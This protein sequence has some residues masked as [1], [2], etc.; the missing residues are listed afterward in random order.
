MARTPLLVAL[1]F[2]LAL[3]STASASGLNLAW[4]DC[5]SF[6]TPARTFACDTNAGTHVLVASLVAPPGI[7]SCVA[8]EIVIDLEVAAPTLNPWLDFTPNACRMNRA[9]TAFTFGDLASCLDP[10]SGQGLGASDF[11]T[12]YPQLNRER[13][14]TVGAVPEAAAIP[15]SPGGEYYMVEL[16]I[17]NAKTVGTG[18]CAG[19]QVQGIFEFVSV[20]ITQPILANF[21][22]VITQPNQP[23]SNRVVWQGDAVVPV[24]NRTWGAIKATYR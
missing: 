20:K 15:L 5:G 14:R 24:R 2:T 10:W 23:N 7:S 3:Y 17:T 22:P 1:A 11:E 21:D 8:A 6:G 18:S 13:I 16:V 19:C 12:N 4:N 9:F